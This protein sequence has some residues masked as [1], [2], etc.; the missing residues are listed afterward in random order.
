MGRNIIICSDG[1]GN[2]FDSRVTNVTH[3]IKCLALD[4]RKQQVVVYDQGVGTSA[5]R[6]NVVDA[7]KKALKD[8]GALHVLPPP[9]ESKFRPKAWFDR[10]RGLLFGYGLKENVREMYR[11]LSNLHEGPDDRVFLF[12]F[13]VQS[14]TQREALVLHLLGSVQGC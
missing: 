14:R 8:Q 10:G 11:V 4:N 12:G 3:V 13:T 1:T 6:Q 2:T 7:Y 5:N 9:L